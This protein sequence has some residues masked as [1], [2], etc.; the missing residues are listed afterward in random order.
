MSSDESYDDVLKPKRRRYQKHT[1]KRKK[2]QGIQHQLD[3]DTPRS[4]S[5]DLQS[6]FE[7]LVLKSDSSPYDEF[8][9]SQLLS[10]YHQERDSILSQLGGKDDN[11]TDLRLL[12]RLEESHLRDDL[13]AF[14]RLATADYSPMKMLA[15]R[16]EYDEHKVNLPTI[17]LHAS[18]R[19]CSTLPAELD[20]VLPG[21]VLNGLQGIS[22]T[23]YRCSFLSRL[24]AGPPNP[25]NT[26][27]V[28]WDACS[29]WMSLMEDIRQHY[30]F[31]HPDH[32]LPLEKAGIIE[33]GT[34]QAWHLPQVH[35]LLRRTF[36]DG[37]DVSDSLDYWPERCT[38]VA[39]YKHLV[40]GIV[41]ISSPTETYITY[42]VVRAGWDNSQIATAL[43]YHL[44][45]LNPQKDITLHVSANSPAILL[46]NR[47][48]FKAEEF[49]VGF[50]EDYLSPQSR[51]SRNAFRLR[52]RHNL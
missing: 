27:A 50:Y 12:S 21:H 25:G 44:I 32:E 22:T 42:L 40:L 4:T 49:V 43:L 3:N 29:P 30:R 24:E 14:S 35:D 18:L 52:L 5:H 9:E 46:Y 7:H 28:D 10:E 8:F 13:S 38:V 16:L 47:F 45:Q 1:G 20:N 6:F 31:A 33:Y 34:L 39:T 41:I 2:R 37:I 11:A 48:G 19:E 36:W 23:P 26:V 51:A 15:Y 17:P